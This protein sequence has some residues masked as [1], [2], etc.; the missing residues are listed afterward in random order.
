MLRLKLRSSLKYLYPT[1]WILRIP[2]PHLCYSSRTTTDLPI[3]T[4]REMRDV[5]EGHRALDPRPSVPASHQLHQPFEAVFVSSL[6]HG[7]AKR[8]PSDKFARR[9]GPSAVYAR[10]S[11]TSPF[12]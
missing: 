12:S 5:A 1:A 11:T 10:R 9:V 6:G 3:F 4:G 7:D 2:R 8:A